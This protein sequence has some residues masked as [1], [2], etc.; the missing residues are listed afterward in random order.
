MPKRRKLLLGATLAVVALAAVIV[1]PSA[2]AYEK[3]RRQLKLK[4]LLYTA[5]NT[6]EAF[7]VEADEDG[8]LE[9]EEEGERDYAALRQLAR[10]TVYGDPTPEVQREWMQTAR[11]EAER[12]P[13]KMPGARTGRAA[14]QGETWVNI[15]PADAYFQWNGSTYSQ[16]DSGRASG[17]LIDPRDANV[18]YLGVSSG[19]VWKT[20][21]FV[22]K[23]PNPTWHPITE[24]L[25]N[26]SIGAMDLAEESP[27]TIFVAT[28]DAFDVDGNA[29]FRSTNGGGTWDEPVFLLANYPASAGGKSFAPRN[30]RDLKIDQSRPSVVLVGTDVGLFRSED[31][32]KTFGV[33][34]LPNSEGVQRPESI[35]SIA[36]L[37]AQNGESHWLASGVSAC[38]PDWRPPGTNGV[39]AGELSSALDGTA[40]VCVGG[41]RGELWRSSDSGKSWVALRGLNNVLPSIPAKGLGR[42]SLA[43]GK[44]KTPSTTVAYAYVG[45][46]A[47]GTETVAFWRTVGGISW[48]DASGTLANPTNGT[49]CRNWPNLGNDQTWYNQAIAVDPTNDNNVLVGGNLCGVR[50]TSGLS[51]KPSWENVSHWLPTGGGGDTAGGRL[52]Y[53]HADW[54]VAKISAV[55]GVVR[56]FAGSDGGLFTSANLFKVKPTQVIF[57]HHNR[58]LASHLCYSAGSGD[59]ATGNPFVVL[60]GLQDNGT[61]FRDYLRWFASATYAVGDVVTPSNPNGHSYR[62]TTAGVAGAS[63]P[64]WPT[65]AGGTVTDGAVTWQE[66]GATK[67]TVFNQVLG[68]D[69]IGSAVNKGNTGEWIWASI[70]N[71]VAYCH[72]S[73]K[74]CNVGANGVWNRLSALGGEGIPFLVRYSPIQTDPT[75]AG[76]LVVSNNSI[77][78]SAQTGTTGAAADQ[79]TFTRVG[80][81]FSPRAARNVFASQNIPNLYGVALSGG[82]FAVTSDGATWT[83]SNQ[84]GLNNAATPADRMSFTSSIA[85]PITT[86]PG[87]NPGDVFIGA[88][89]AAV[90]EDQQPVP[91]VMGRIFITNDRG[92]TWAPFHG[93]GTG[94]DLPNVPVT[95]VRYDPGDPTNNT[96]Y[97]GTHYGLYRSKDG[98]ATWERYGVGLPLVRIEDLF[99]AR[100]SSLIRVATFGRG[101]WEIYPEATAPQGVIGNGDFDRNQVIDFRDVAAL[102]ARLGTTPATLT[103]PTYSW[104][105]DVTGPV[106]GPLVNAIDEED[107]KVVLGKFGSNP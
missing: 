8:P 29:V 10:R 78:K 22:D 76:V 41:N 48:A 3:W 32:G 38:A 67:P 51:A 40:Q 13:E 104:F 27:D 15:G 74:N 62:A 101:L 63:E 1:A 83:I 19:G 46:E 47:G 71:T 73:A 55:G 65:A 70:Q 91:A 28:G 18:V 106:N 49:N 2:R 105:S 58:G 79:L 93:N 44:A 24:T 95:V 9:S 39:S 5:P 52:Q 66:V 85:F 98:G 64:A 75:G 89:T 86:P 30:A 16:V 80:A 25:G 17:I 43:A 88:T 99:I 57:D 68:G 103:W 77:F 7:E 33:V 21:D 97:A 61:R 56:A 81:S 26:L 37:G 36:Y 96:I 11:R 23:A 50:T 69:G 42:I 14:V 60:S 84:I 4:S 45:N 6:L 53:V 82:R 87:K 20:Y 92:T 100:N 102:A 31:S 12:W 59:P 34:D 54:H 35:W 72:A 94:K 107:L 90:T